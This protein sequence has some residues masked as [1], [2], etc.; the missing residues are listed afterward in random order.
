MR[1]ACLEPEGRGKLGVIWRG[2]L[3]ELCDLIVPYCIPPMEPLAEV[4]GSHD[5]V[6]AARCIQVDDQQATPPVGRVMSSRVSQGV[7]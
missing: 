4:K 3:S 7:M 5:H 6:S 2:F 1:Q